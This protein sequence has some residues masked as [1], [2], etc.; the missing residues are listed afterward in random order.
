MH[1]HIHTCTHSITLTHCCV[2]INFK[3]IHST[4]AKQFLYFTSFI[5]TVHCKLLC[6]AKRQPQTENTNILFLSITVFSMLLY[7]LTHF[8][9]NFNPLFSPQS[10]NFLCCFCFS[11]PFCIV[12]LIIFVLQYNT[13]ESFN[14][15]L[16]YLI[17]SLLFSAF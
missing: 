17:I 8:K 1:M 3:G 11:S 13:G 9:N 6:E 7:F 14:P 16:L 4:K 12:K 5:I 15:L 2:Y 10:S